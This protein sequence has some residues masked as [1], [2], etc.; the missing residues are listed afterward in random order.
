MDSQIADTTKLVTKLEKVPMEILS[1][2]LQM[3]H[4]L[5]HTHVT[6]GICT[7]CKRDLMAPTLENM[8]NGITV[9]KVALGKCGHAFHSEC[10]DKYIR[11]SVSCPIDMTPWNLERILDQDI[12]F[13]KIIQSGAKG[14]QLAF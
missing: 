9:S 14:N 1:L 13:K 11:T 10:I 12:Q 6:N 4:N 3:V 7:I 5:K 8:N 2:N